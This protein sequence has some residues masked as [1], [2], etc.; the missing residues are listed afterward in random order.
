MIGPGLQESIC[1]ECQ[2]CLLIEDSSTEYDCK[3]LRVVAQNIRRLRLAQN[4]SQQELSEMA[5]IHRTYLARMETRAINISLSVLLR[6]ALALNT[7]SRELLRP[8]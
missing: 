8:E 7:D 2:T 5:N 3:A 1:G 6:L 4:L